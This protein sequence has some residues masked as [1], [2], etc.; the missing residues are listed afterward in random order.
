M[1]E[2]SEALQN[3]LNAIDANQQPGDAGELIA[4]KVRGL[5]IGYDYRWSRSRYNM[6]G[7]EEVFHLPVVN[8]KTGA[9][10]RT[11][12]QAGKFDGIIEI[13]GR[14]YLLEH[15]TTSDDIADPDA[16]YWGILDIDSQVS[17]YAL[18]NWQM[19][20]KLDGTVYDVIR[21]PGIRP[22]DIAK[23]QQKLIVS[24]REYCGFEVPASIA[25]AVSQGQEREC[26]KLY[27]MR[28]AAET[29]ENPNKYFQRRIIPRL[30]ADLVE[31]ASEM[32]DV[33]QSILHARANNSHYRNSGA[34][35]NYNTPCTFLGV[36]RGMD[37]IDSDKWKKRDSRHAELPREFKDEGLNVLSNSRIKCF[38]TCRRK[39]LY[40]YEMGIERVDAE[41][42]EA[43]A[44]GTLM[45]HGLEAWFH[46]FMKGGANAPSSE[47]SSAVIEV[48]GE[49]VS[50][51]ELSF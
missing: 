1:H 13:D 37:S 44:L 22:K 32:W 20:R 21:K 26:A 33:G 43:L 36:C 18:A 6:V 41:E 45:H 15:K 34:C 23:A 35:M 5:M 46:T 4:A 31:Y 2:H 10:S 49:S 30:D 9:K 8:P 28:L 11:F 39:H 48:A 24:E 47:D 17:A 16:P 40:Q 38:Q 19:G 14:H 25:L 27:E 12:T 42:R 3:A 51:K 29:L 50:Q 7:V